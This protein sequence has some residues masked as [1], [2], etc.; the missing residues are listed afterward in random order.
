MTVNV[1]GPARP[2]LLDLCGGAGGGAV[3]YH[4]AGFDVVG[5]DLVPQPRYPFAFIEGDALEVMDRLLAGGDLDGWRLAD[6][7]AVHASPPCQ[8]W[9]QATL[10]QRRAGKTYP[11]LLTPLRPRLARL[12]VPWVMEN[13]PRAP[14]RPDYKLCGCMFGLELPGVGQLRRERWF[15]TSWHAAASQMPHRHWGPAISIAGHGTPQWMRARTG[16]VGVAT[17]RQ[18]MG[19][20][21]TTRQ[22]LTEA[23]PP[24]YCELVGARL[25]DHISARRAA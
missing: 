22:E 17:W 7:A 12:S 5:V 6:F 23:V 24:A 2:R 21:W 11:D 1:H 19:V 8:R 16:H 14:L 25:L 4:R 3:G 13:V 10:G 18:V 20:S 15:E 9:A